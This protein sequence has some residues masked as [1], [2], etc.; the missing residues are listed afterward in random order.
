MS[1]AEK[2]ERRHRRDL[3]THRTTISP[4]PR[5]QREVDRKLTFADRVS[6]DFSR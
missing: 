1:S 4:G 6:D 5:P 3:I 2:R